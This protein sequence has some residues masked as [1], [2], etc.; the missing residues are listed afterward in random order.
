[1]L[2]S[3]NI[4]YFFT[5]GTKRNCICF[6]SII[7]LKDKVMSRRNSITSAFSKASESLLFCILRNSKSW[8][9]KRSMRPVLLSIKDTEEA[10]SF[11]SFPARCIFSKAFCI[12]VKGVR[13]SCEMF[14]KNTSLYSVSCSSTLIWF[15]RAFIFEKILNAR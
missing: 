1:M 15:R 4:S 2:R 13:N 8:F 3:I 14:V 5:D 7:S 6:D 12:K 9:I 10:I 11:G